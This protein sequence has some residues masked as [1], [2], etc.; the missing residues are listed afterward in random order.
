MKSFRFPTLVFWFPENLSILLGNRDVQKTVL[1]NSLAVRRSTVFGP[2]DQIRQT[3]YGRAASS[4]QILG[5]LKII[6]EFP[7][8]SDGFENSIRISKKNNPHFRKLWYIEHVLSNTGQVSAHYLVW[9]T[10]GLSIRW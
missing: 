10:A 9:R 1:P 7:A 6:A 2:P 4:F 5:F 3:Q 8:I